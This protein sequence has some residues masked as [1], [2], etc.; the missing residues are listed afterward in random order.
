[1]CLSG[2]PKRQ[3]RRGLYG[4]EAFSFNTQSLQFFFDLGTTVWT[5]VQV[6]VGTHIGTVIGHSVMNLLLSGNISLK[7]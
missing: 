4:R 7:L 3:S 6:D 5:L 1:M 2:R